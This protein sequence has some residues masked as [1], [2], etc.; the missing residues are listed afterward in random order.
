MLG[1]LHRKADRQFFIFGHHAYLVVKIS[2]RKSQ[3]NIL[4]GKNCRKMDT[5]D[6]E[7]PRQPANVHADMSACLSA[8]RE[9]T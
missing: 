4:S 5:L 8:S 9:S 6:L 3:K 2:I 1:Q 7:K